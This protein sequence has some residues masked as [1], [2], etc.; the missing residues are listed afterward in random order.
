MADEP[1]FNS[2]PDWRQI[3]IDLHTRLR[4]IEQVVMYADTS[5]ALDAFDAA[6]AQEVANDE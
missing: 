1:P 2:E 6:M 5:D 3:A 4:K